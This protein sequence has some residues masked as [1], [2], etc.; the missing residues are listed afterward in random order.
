MYSKKWKSPQ[1]VEDVLSYTM[2]SYTSTI[3]DTYCLIFKCTTESEEDVK[4]I[5]RR[6][7][8]VC[9]SGSVEKEALCTETFA[10]VF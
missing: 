8:K 2:K 6:E 10:P 9:K 7:R 1:W 5:V 3:K 4:S